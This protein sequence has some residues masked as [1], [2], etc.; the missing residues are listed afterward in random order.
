MPSLMHNAF[1]LT[2]RPGMETINSFDMELLLGPTDV[3]VFER[4]HRL[5]VLI[6]LPQ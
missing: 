2:K 4:F 3:R 1:A 5:L 6:P